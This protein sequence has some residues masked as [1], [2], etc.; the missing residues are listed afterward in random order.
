MSDTAIRL[1][2]TSDALLRDLDALG[3]LEE[4]KRSV[5]PSD[6]R[7]TDLATRIH[8]IAARVLARSEHQKELTEIVAADPEAVDDLPIED[9]ERSPAAILAEWRA[10]EARASA[11]DQEAPE[12]EELR[13]IADRLREEYRAAFEKRRLP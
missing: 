5:L 12:A 13:I 10:A 9:M 6:P 3:A 7:L 1:R 2:A 11:V 8:E 4:E